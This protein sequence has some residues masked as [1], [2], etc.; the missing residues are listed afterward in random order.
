MAAKD[1]ERRRAHDRA[2]KRPQGV[3]L[4]LHPITKL[5]PPMGDGEFQELVADIQ[6]HGQREAIWLYRGEVIDGAHRLKACERLGLAVR[7]REWDGTGSLTGFVISM[8]LRR[9]HLTASQKAMIAEGAL[10]MF[11]AEAKEKMLA[12]KGDPGAIVPQGARAPRA[13]DQ[14]AAAVG[15]SPRYV[16]DAKRLAKQAP[17]LADDVRRGGLTISAAVQRL[18]RSSRSTGPRFARRPSKRPPMERFHKAIIALTTAVE[19]LRA[20]VGEMA[21]ADVSA[22]DRQSLSWARRTLTHLIRRIQGG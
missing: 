13:R 19:V 6:E 9:R 2:M 14:A 20:A 18:P 10:P 1:L 11:E 17:A 8:N 21:G 5:F 22:R 15:V 12:G 3:S 4:N 7:S 16:Q